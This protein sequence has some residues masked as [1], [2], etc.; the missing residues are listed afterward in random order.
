MNEVR[1]RALKYDQDDFLHRATP[2]NLGTKYEEQNS[3]APKVVKRV[4]GMLD[5]LSTRRKH[6]TPATD[7]LLL[8]PLER[9]REGRNQRSN[10]EGQNSTLSVSSRTSLC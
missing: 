6:E 4:D 10:H 2:R 1:T 9:G 3:G 8:T 5:L 7:R